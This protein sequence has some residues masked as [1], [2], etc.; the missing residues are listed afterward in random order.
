M[1]KIITNI[2]AISLITLLGLG[3]FN[4]N[5]YAEDNASETDS[6]PKTG[7]TL[8]PVSRV[9]PLNSSSEYDGVFNVT[10]D[11]DADTNVLIYTAPYSYV[12]SDE[13]DAY[14]L[15]FNNQNNFTQ[16]TRWISI[17]DEAGNYVSRTTLVIKAHETAEISYK[18][19]TPENIPAGGQYAVIFVQT[20]TSGATTNG[21][22]TEASAGM[23]I[24]GHSLEGE[25]VTTAEITDLAI[26]KNSESQNTQNTGANAGEQAKIGYHASAKVK[27]TGNTDFYAQGK[28]KI[29]PIIGFSTYETP[30]DKGVVSVI[31][32]AQMTVEDNWTEVPGFGIYKATWTVSVGDHSESIEQILFLI[33]PVTIIITIIVLTAVTI[34]IIMVVRKRKERRSRLAV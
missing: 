3:V 24:Y 5:T 22:R 31:P 9:L 2:L 1:K 33:S 11:G 13:E 20:E 14:K 19:T 23:V 28:L 25:A 34:W 32:E 26:T 16:I 29:E 6:S 10:N 12:Y 8:M 7:L 18:V 30:E 15:G 27:N 21:I 4:S 17:K